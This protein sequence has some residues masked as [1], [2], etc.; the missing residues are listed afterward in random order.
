MSSRRADWRVC[1]AR[2]VVFAA[3]LVI[4]S[5]VVLQ[6]QAPPPSRGAFAASGHVAVTK[7]DT[8]AATDIGLGGRVAWHPIR[9]L[10]IE[11]ELTVYPSEIPDNPAVSRRRTEALFGVTVGPTFGRF[12]PFARVRPGFMGF[13]EAPRPF[14]CILIFPPP[15]DCLMAAGHTLSAL[16][17]GGGV[18][19]DVTDRA[20][21]RVDVGDRLLKYPG[22][23]F[24]RGQRREAGFTAHELRVAVGGGMRF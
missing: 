6:A 16:D 20:F 9:A 10:G 7:M 14:A 1:C 17:V 15:L 23:S 8:L 21:L 3:L 22:P 2:A 5:G 19:L 4:L 24:D 13:D 18:D 11:A 12:R